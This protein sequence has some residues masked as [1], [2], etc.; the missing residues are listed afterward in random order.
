MSK[1]VQIDCNQSFLLPPDLRD[2]LLD[3]ALAC[4]WVQIRKVL[5]G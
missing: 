2:W 3:D 1:F 5:K 4:S